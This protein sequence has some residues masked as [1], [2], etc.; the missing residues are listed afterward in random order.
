MY[1]A[2][3]GVGTLILNDFD[4]V[5]VSNLQR[6]IIHRTSSVG[7]NK[8]ASAKQTL[9]ALNPCC[10]I[11]EIAGKLE[12]KKM[13]ELVASADIVVDCCDNF[14]TRGLLNT[15]CCQ[16]KTPLVSGA[17][18]RFEGQVTVFHYQ[19]DSD[20]CYACL[21]PEVGEEDQS[22]SVN[23]VLSPI[24]GVIGALQAVEA[25]KLIIGVGETLRNRLMLFDG[26]VQDFRV[27]KY[28]KDL[29]CRV[30]GNQP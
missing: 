20:A 23:G 22:C 8:V 16:H 15:L 13:S 21:Y 26:L 10:S 11:S 4:T 25:L 29:Q 27:V 24:V 19:D 7:L 17:A 12:E 3:S 30:C 28:K 14:A 2:A 18:I 1:L 5:D 9:L 6:Q